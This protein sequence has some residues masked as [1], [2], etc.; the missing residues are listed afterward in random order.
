MQIQDI[1]T[2]ISNGALD[3]HLGAIRR[4]IKARETLLAG[5]TIAALAPG[6]TVVIQNTRPTYLNGQQ[7]T[8]EKVNDKTVTVRFSNPIA[9]RRFG[10]GRV[11]VPST[12]LNPT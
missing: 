9:A 11:R 1:I 4:A 6:D 7:A 10:N 5:L 3:N 12:C 2:A 8:V